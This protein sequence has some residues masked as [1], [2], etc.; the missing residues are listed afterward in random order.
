MASAPP[1]E[2]K[3]AAVGAIAAPSE[4]ARLQEAGTGQSSQ[5]KAMV[6]A[7]PQALSKQSSTAESQGMTSIENSGNFSRREVPSNNLAVMDAVTESSA[8]GGFH[9]STA[10]ADKFQKSASSHLAIWR[11]GPHGLIQKNVSEDKW[12]TKTSGVDADLLGI[13]FFNADIGWVVGKFGT[14]LHTTDGGETWSKISSPANEDI[15]SIKTT[16]AESAEIRTRS[17][18]AFQTS[19]SGHTWAKS[20]Q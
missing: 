6:Q 13:A 3:P 1:V 16:G 4:R 11:V 7:Q 10:P 19:D 2:A 17:G 18:L 9:Y 8:K 15:V 20:S 12:E 14:I 5:S